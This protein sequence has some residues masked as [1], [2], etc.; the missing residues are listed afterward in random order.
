[1]RRNFPSAPQS[2]E[3]RMCTNMFSNPILN[4]AGGV[5]VVCPTCRSNMFSA[6]TKRAMA[7]ARTATTGTERTGKTG[8]KVE[9]TVTTPTPAV[10]AKHDE[11]VFKSLNDY[12]SSLLK[13]P[14]EE[15]TQ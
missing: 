5:S 13:A 7:R 11:F 1:M 4:G 10:T 15:V 12:R 9:P 14:S 2:I 3:C 8:A 6:K